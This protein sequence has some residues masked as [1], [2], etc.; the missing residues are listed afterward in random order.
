MANSINECTSGLPFIPTGKG[1]ARGL[2]RSVTLLVEVDQLTAETSSTSHKD[3]LAI[4][5]IDRA[6]SVKKRN[7]MK[8]TFR[9]R[10]LVDYLD[11]HLTRVTQQLVFITTSQSVHSR[12][13]SVSPSLICRASP[14]RCSITPRRGRS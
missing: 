9:V 14:T 4:L 2:A 11:R 8:V 6:T 7:G 3:A 5:D 1:T 12:L 10:L 13:F